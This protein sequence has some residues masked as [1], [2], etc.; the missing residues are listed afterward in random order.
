MR[1]VDDEERGPP[2]RARRSPHVAELFRGEEDESVAPT[3]GPPEGLAV[4][5]RPRRVQ[6][7]C[8]ARLAPSRSAARP[9]P[10]AARSAGKQ[11][12]PCR[13]TNAGDLVDRGLACSR[14]QT[15]RVSRPATTACIAASW[16]GPELLE[17]ENLAREL[18]DA[19]CADRGRPPAGLS[20]SIGWRRGGTDPG[21]PRPVT[22][23]R[24]GR[25]RP[26]A[27]SDRALPRNRR[28]AGRGDSC[29]GGEASGEVAVAHEHADGVAEVHAVVVLLERVGQGRFA[30]GEEHAG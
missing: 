29:F 4:G 8:A 30:V 6:I 9:G 5:R 14:R 21:C 28:S 25:D 20:S 18:A 3:P 24:W 10:A 11:R 17:A 1:L 26:L 2:P 19:P 23:K 12:P 27:R 7:G 16:P 15:T 22:A 13:R